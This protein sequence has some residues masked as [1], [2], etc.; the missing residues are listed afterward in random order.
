MARPR[1]AERA[2]WDVRREALLD[3]LA[4][5]RH[6][7]GVRPHGRRADEV[8]ADLLGHLARLDVEVVE[9]FEVIRHEADRRDDDVLDATCPERA[10]VV[11]DVRLEPRN[12]RRPA[13]ALED[14]AVVPGARLGG[15][16]P[17]RLREL[18]LVAAMPGHRARDRVR[19][20]D[21]VGPL[22]SPRGNLGKGGR[23]VLRVRPDEPGVVEERTGA[24]DLGR[25]VADL[26]LSGEEVLAV[27]AAAGVGAV[28]GRE[29][30][31]RPA[32]AAVGHLTQNVG[33][34][35]MP[36]AVSEVDRQV[37][38]VGVELGA[39]RGDER[40]VLRVDRADAVE[41]L[42]V[43]GDLLEP[44]ARDAAPPGDVLEEG[45][46]VVHALGPAERDD[47]DRVEER[48]RVT[49]LEPVGRRLSFV[50]DRGH[51]RAER[52]NALCQACPRIDTGRAA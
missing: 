12:R 40:P 23:Q 37:D 4:D 47:E 8:E 48:G 50:G 26:D 18:G 27:L 49:A 43:A 3:Q 15:H 31:E 10:Q 33:Q 29:E 1:L 38:A 7:G 5:H 17:P 9:N 45:H 42:V 44:L 13:P 36:V 19:R 51:P 28:G 32:D 20:E 30:R 52:S 11:A 24:Q 2:S 16:E 34:E 39:E 35:G 22:A 21:D 6:E 46:H 14:E 41:P 25:L